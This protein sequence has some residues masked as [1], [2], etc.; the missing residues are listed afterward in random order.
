MLTAKQCI[1]I[2]C[3]AYNFIASLHNTTLDK[4]ESGRMRLWNA[5]N[6]FIGFCEGVLGYPLLDK[7]PTIPTSLISPNVMTQWII[8]LV[9]AIKQDKSEQIDS[10]AK[11]IVQIM[12]GNFKDVQN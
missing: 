6:A 10:S 7:Y 5:F 1:E 3:R 2:D 12:K 11:T 4:S 9:E 8:S